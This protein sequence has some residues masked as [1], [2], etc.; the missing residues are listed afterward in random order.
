MKYFSILFLFLI[1]VSCN[2]KRQQVQ[3][4]TNFS[5]QEQE[6]LVVSRKIITDCYFGTFIS[7]DQNGQ[8]RARVMEP[9]APED[10][11]TIWMAT[12]PKSRKVAQIENN[13]R[14]TLHYFDKNSMGYV[15][16]M[17]KA[18]IINDKAIK[19]QKW[20]DGWEKF[21]QNQEDAYLLI[22]F[23]P[24]TLELISISNGFTGDEST[25]QPHRILLYE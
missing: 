2:Q 23:I 5:Q 10:D 9:F 16:L 6:I 7:I 3:Y 15:S 12:N 19:S 14:A 21:Y 24:E 18:F 25:W 4:R 13:L 8:P 1:Q 22:K 17:G 20:K 11:F